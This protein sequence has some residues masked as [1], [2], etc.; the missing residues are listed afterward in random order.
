M[1][2]PTG[3]RQWRHRVK[4]THESNANDVQ[5]QVMRPDEKLGLWITV[6]V[7]TMGFFAVLAAWILIWVVWN[8]GPFHHFDPGPAFVI[9]LLVSNFIQLLLMPLIMVG[10]NVQGRHQ[11][12]QAD[13]DH[14]TLTYL[15]QINETQLK[16]LHEVH[17]VTCVRDGASGE[18]EAGGKEALAD[19]SVTT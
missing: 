3:R 5:S 6:H 19:G 1:Q 16:I 9:L 17:A 10:Q 7:G 2:A 12:I 11:E 8:L 4:V 14:Q 18:A 13:V 15:R